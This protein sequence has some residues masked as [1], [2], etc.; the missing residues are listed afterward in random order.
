MDLRMQHATSSALQLDP[1]DR[2]IPTVLR[3]SAER[4]GAKPCVSVGATRLS[5]DEVRDEAARVAGALAGAGIN[6]GDRVVVVSENRWEVLALWLGCAW[7]GAVF[8]P[9]NAASR[10]AQ[11]EHILGNAAP[12]AAAVE[13]NLVGRLAELDRLPD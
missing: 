6:P 3:R 12:R 5:Y 11:L 13:G 2:T 9:V 10:G 1:H 4:Y 7:R 8:V